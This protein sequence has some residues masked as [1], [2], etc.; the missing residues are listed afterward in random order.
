LGLDVAGIKYDLCY[1]FKLIWDEWAK[2]SGSVPILPKRKL[3]LKNALICTL[4]YFTLKNN[5]LYIMNN[6]L[7]KNDISKYYSIKLFYLP[8]HECL[9]F[10]LSSGDVR[11][12]AVPN[13]V[14]KNIFHT[15][16]YLKH[17]QNYQQSPLARVV[18]QRIRFHFIVDVAF[19]IAVT[20]LLRRPVL[21]WPPRLKVF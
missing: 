11:R 14:V 4:P 8:I 13:R 5:Y 9:T 15:L 6:P 17:V 21:Y 12:R 2:L 3:C 10:V 19:F 16:N 20:L 7:L 18:C 1:F